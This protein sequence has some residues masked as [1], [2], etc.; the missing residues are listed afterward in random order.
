MYNSIPFA[1]RSGNIDIEV[2]DALS[3][4]YLDLE[5]ISDVY[6]PSTGSFLDYIW[7][8]YISI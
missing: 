1:L 2:T 8:I 3:A 6:E 4:N 7:G 5:T